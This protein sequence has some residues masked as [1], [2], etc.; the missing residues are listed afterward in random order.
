VPDYELVPDEEVGKFTR[1]RLAKPR[2]PALTIE[3]YGGRLIY[4]WFGMRFG[5]LM[6]LFQRGRYSFT[7]NCIPDT[8]LLFLWVPW[9]S[10]LYW[11]SEAKY[12]KQA[13]ALPLD[14]PPVFVIGHWRTGTT[15][16]HDLFSVDP[17][18]AY[19]TTFECFFPHHF[20]LT[21]RVLPKVMKR[22]LPK[23][24]PQDDVPVGFDRPQE[25]EFGM[26]MLGEGTPYLTCAWPRLGP[27]DTEYLDFDGVSEA[28]RNKWAD[29][30]MWLY[31]R[32]AL[33]HG[34]PL[35]MKTPANAARLKLLTELFPD[36]RYVYLARNPLNVFP[37]T[38][39]LWRALYSVQGLH[40]P[41]RLDPWLDDY[42]LDM[43]AR[44]TEAYEEDRH[45]IPKDRLVELRYEDF[46]KDPV[47]AMRDIYRRLDIPNFE[48]AEG[49][50]RE[51][52]A[53]RAEHQ[54][55]RYDMPAALKRKIAERLKPFIDRF[56]YRQ[57]IDAALAK[58]SAAPV[59]ETEPS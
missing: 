22:L 27:A 10:V 4:F 6:K 7:L 23:K 39:K 46:I 54:V 8:L 44:L 20:L 52:I 35:V 1:R 2:L 34:K 15:F 9:N 14:Q 33:K 30:Y 18:L 49:K 29:A 58:P 53:E 32:L 24:R 12:K 17:N 57:A 51:F 3:R 38:V 59:R 13:E 42:V 21:E 56:G 41:P 36:A 45:L 55:S 28:D 25:E 37:S 47:A 19:P 48:Q 11:I 40:N 26:M 5:A 43:F 50:M 16:L 31:R